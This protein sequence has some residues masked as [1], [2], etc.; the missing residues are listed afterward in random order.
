[1][2][3]FELVMA[4]NSSLAMKVR[5][6]GNNL[7]TSQYLMEILYHS[8]EWIKGYRMIPDCLNLLFFLR[9]YG[10]KFP[11]IGERVEILPKCFCEIKYI[12]FLFNLTHRVH[13]IGH[14]KDQTNASTKFWAQ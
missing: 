3:I 14:I 5:F 9:S 2:L 6:F 8:T 7:A 12:K 11:K 13:G 4:R 1:M 10:Q